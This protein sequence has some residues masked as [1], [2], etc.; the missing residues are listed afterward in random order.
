M[1]LKHPVQKRASTNTYS[2]FN[3]CVCVSDP[4]MP[5][6]LV[7]LFA[8]PDVALDCWVTALRDWPR[9]DEGLELMMKT[10]SRVWFV[11]VYDLLTLFG[12]LFGG[13]LHKGND[14]RQVLWCS[15]LG[16]GKKR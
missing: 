15:L 12:A 11:G 14:T 5:A 7:F 4:N 16:C 6:P 9:T 10:S 8:T 2:C 3:G 1:S 13:V